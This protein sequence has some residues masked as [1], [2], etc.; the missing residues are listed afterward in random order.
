MVL[1]SYLKP[2]DDSIVSYLK[3]QNLLVQG[4]IENN[5]PELES[6]W[7]GVDSP[8]ILYKY[9]S[10]LA[11]FDILS[12]NQAFQAGTYLL[13]SHLL[14]LGSKPT[15][16]WVIDLVDSYK[17]IFTDSIKI[18]WNPKPIENENTL[19][20]FVRSDESNISLE[21]FDEFTA[22]VQKN[23]ESLRL[24][25]SDRQRENK[26]LWWISIKHTNSASNQ[27]LSYRSFDKMAA[28]LYMAYDVIQL[29]K[30]DIPAPDKVKAV[31]LEC[32]YS[33]WPDLG[34]SE[35]R[36]DITPIKLAIENNK[37]HFIKLNQDNYF[38]KIIS[39]ID[40]PTI[41]P[42]DFS[43]LIFDLLQVKHLLTLVEED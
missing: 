16:D 29:L 34:F 28:G 25:V 26:L 22:F 20:E 42:M 15:H 37:K 17:L 12:K 8:E 19:E 24:L 18:K 11:L 32:L 23:D 40:N 43:I 4:L 39:Y 5:H 27:M 3:D 35:N 36:S 9:I 30:N 6:G 7:G 1:G 38:N 14:S 10:H 13:L 33:I 2:Y 31:I 21:E 41:S